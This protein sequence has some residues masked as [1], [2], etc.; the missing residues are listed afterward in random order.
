MRKSIGAFGRS[1]LERLGLWVGR[2][3]DIP[4]GVGWRH[5]LKRLI[6]HDSAATFFDV[7]A[8]VGQTAELLAES[9]PKATI[10]SFEP[11]P[12]T[13]VEL[14][15]NTAGLSRVE[16]VD[17]AL[18]ATPG[19][20]T[21]TTDRNVLNTMTP[22][23]SSQ[24]LTTVQVDTVDQFCARRTIKRVGLLKIDTE[25]FEVSVLQG[26]ATMLAEGRIDFALVECDFFRRPD[27]PHG[28]FFE[29]HDLLAPQGFRVVSF[30]TGGID[31][32]GWVWGD[33]LLMR[34]GCAD[35]L[36]LTMSPFGPPVEPLL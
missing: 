21:I 25:G 7:G 13:F 28:D 11:V 23:V 35:H 34:Q 9:F 16:C 33:V 4:Y 10:Y 30:Y 12:A 19:E 22:D 26:A 17:L 2:S 27:E 24:A 20:A 14:S 18:G 31:R 6:G 32:R 1:V 5:D 8:N 36:P 3:V 29:V 15:R